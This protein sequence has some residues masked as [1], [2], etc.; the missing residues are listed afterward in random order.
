MLWNHKLVRNGEDFLLDKLQNGSVLG[1]K[2][3]RLGRIRDDL[4]AI[5]DRWFSAD[6]TMSGAIYGKRLAKRLIVG[7]AHF[8]DK[9]IVSGCGEDCPDL[10]TLRDPVDSFLRSS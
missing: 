4:G 6:C 9:V 10:V 5:E 3:A 7:N 1:G 2:S 8:T